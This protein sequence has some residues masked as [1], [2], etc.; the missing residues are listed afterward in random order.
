[1]ISFIVNTLRTFIFAALL[2]DYLKRNHPEKYKDFIVTFSYNVIYLYS[3]IKILYINTAKIVNKKI[4]ENPKLLKL[5][6]DLDLLLKSKTGMPTMLEYV[7]NG[8]SVN[9]ISDKGDD[10]CDFMIYSWL[11]DSKNC[12][13]KK[14]VYDLQEPLSFSEV[15]ET[16]F[17]LVEIKL[18]EENIH[19]VDFKT[20]EFNFYIIGNKFTRQFFIYYLKQ[21][22]KNDEEVNDETKIYLKII[23]NNVDTIEME[24][25]NKTDGILLEKNG[26]KLINNSKSD[27]NEEKE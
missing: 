24:I 13:N 19:K 27:N 9:I 5:K 15:S 25:T 18:G 11:D 23:D 6:N 17:L 16:K 1:M 4:E 2:N 10:E 21:I 20:D 14:I 7:R 26:Y 8:N 12:L 22:L 3:K